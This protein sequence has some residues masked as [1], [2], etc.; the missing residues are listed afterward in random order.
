MKNRKKLYFRSWYRAIV[1]FVIFLL[2]VYHIFLK[3]L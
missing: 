1:P 3:D 2:S